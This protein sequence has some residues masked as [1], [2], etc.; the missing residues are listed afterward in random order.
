MDD[1]GTV[2]PEDP[3][4]RSLADAIERHRGAFELLDHKWRIVFTGSEMLDAMG[5]SRA[6]AAAYTGHSPIWRNTQLADQW[7]TDDAAGRRWWRTVAPSILHDV[8]SHDPDFEAV[9][10]HRADAARRLRAADPPP[11][12]LTVDQQTSELIASSVSLAEGATFFYLRLHDAKGGFVGILMHWR[13]GVREGLIARLSRGHGAM[14]DRMD[15]MRT[16][17]RRSAAILF[18]D[19]EGS[20]SL[21][22]SL[23]SATYFELIRSL[24]DLIDGAVEAHGGILGK[25]AGDGA[26]ALFVVEPGSGESASARAAIE[27]ARAIREGAGGLRPADAE[28]RINIGLHWGATLTVG[29][30]STGGRL[31]V[32]ALGDEMNETARIEEV[33]REG[34]VYASKA[35]VERLDFGD[36]AALDLKLEGLTFRT[37]GALDPS[38]KALRDAGGVAVVEV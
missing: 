14:F 10:A 37:V 30:V 19:L 32:T 26:S 3:T 24:T 18:A 5:L 23:A 1:P 35:L 38:E 12:A 4:L 7:G 20:G 6:D 33:A 13:P 11:P 15:S 16:A 8:P 29:Q 36:A 21:S 34:A 28:L 25:H 31:E 22:R 9:F 2:L 17:A 27:A